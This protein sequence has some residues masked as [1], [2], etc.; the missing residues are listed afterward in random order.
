MA[1]MVALGASG[2]VVVDDD[3]RDY[4]ACSFDSDCDSFR[5]ESITADWPDR[6][7][8]D[9]ICTVGCIDGL[10]C[11]DT[12][13]GLQ[14]TCAALPGAPFLCYETCIDDGDCAFDFRCGDISGFGDTVCLPY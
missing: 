3:L 5:C 10:D 8:T 14:G 4:E 7:T 11:L 12:R 9:A 6:T 1:A 13:S 2:C